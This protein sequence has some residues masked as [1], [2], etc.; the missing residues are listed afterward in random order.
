MYVDQRQAVGFEFDAYQDAVEKA[1]REG[2]I[3]RST[4][5]MY[6]RHA[7]LFLK[8]IDNEFDPAVRLQVVAKRKAA[9]R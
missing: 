2:H 6:V 5:A 3:S 7:E 9:A 1:V 8:W 4:G